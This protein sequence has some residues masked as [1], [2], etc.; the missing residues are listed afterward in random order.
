MNSGQ[1]ILVNGTFIPADEY[2]VSLQESDAFLFAEKIRAVRTNFPFFS[3]TLEI[4]KLKL[5][6][7]NQ[8]F[9]ELTDRGGAGL[10]RQL[11]RA[12]T[13]NKLFLGA[14]FT[15]SFRLINEQV[16]Y[17]IW[18]EKFEQSDFELNERG[19][20]I[21]IFDKIKKPSSSLSNLS[22]GSEIYWNIARNHLR[23]PVA[24]QLLFVNTEDHIIEALEA[25]I[26]IING[27]R[28][29]GANCEH[30]AYLDISQ[31]LLLE[32]FRKLNLRYSENEEITIHDIRSAE[33]IMTVNAIEGIRWIVGFEGKRFF[34]HT[35]RKISEIF[36]RSLLS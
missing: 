29:R 21:E 30:G 27:N 33:E 16:Q 32:I 26:Y 31:T 22:L 14:V 5:L 8:S 13:K 28:I 1:Y 34:N 19:L 4:I 35:I 18:A 9:P 7:Y 3:E 23:N 36:G 15:I 11:E 10:R 2:R 6:L 12:L 20:F 24:D 17:T 25:N